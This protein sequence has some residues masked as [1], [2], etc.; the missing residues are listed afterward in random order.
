M[1]LVQFYPLGKDGPVREH[2]RRLKEYPGRKAAAA[3][4]GA[5][6]RALQEEGLRSRAVDIKRVTGV[7]GSVW[8]LRRLFEGVAYRIYFCVRKG[9]IWL[10]H[11]IEKKSP[12]IPRDDLDLI[13][14]RAK[15]VLSK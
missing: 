7:A 8:E 13:R 2:L 6:L 3:H 15:E 14:K 4:L 11:S 5:A 12:K 9:E 10:L 1:L